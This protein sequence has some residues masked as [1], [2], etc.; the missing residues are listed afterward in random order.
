MKKQTATIIAVVLILAGLILAFAISPS[1]EMSF[2][3]D[4]HEYVGGDA[5]NIIIEATMRTGD[6]VAYKLG[7]IILISAAAIILAI[8]GKDEN[9]EKRLE[10]QKE[11]LET[12]KQILAALKESSGEKEDPEQQSEPEKTNS[13][14]EH[15]EE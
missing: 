4:V 12:Q 3:K 1:R 2:Y 8:S 7:G 11:I 15:H 14:Q 13:E 10:V 9:A 5:Y 6:R